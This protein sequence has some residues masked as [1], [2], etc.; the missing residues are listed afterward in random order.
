MLL[1]QPITRPQRRPDTE[2]SQA[3]RRE[4]AMKL[5]IASAMLAATPVMLAIIALQALA[6]ASA[7]FLGHQLGSVDPQSWAVATTTV[8]ATGALT[9]GTIAWRRGTAYCRGVAGNARVSGLWLF[10]FAVLA[11]AWMAIVW[12]VGWIGFSH[13]D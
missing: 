6:A 4:F 12:S 5:L 8:V 3:P 11:V 2:P 9:A 7:V 13:G 10:G 1:Q